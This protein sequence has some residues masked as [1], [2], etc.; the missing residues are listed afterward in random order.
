MHDDVYTI[1]KQEKYEIVRLYPEGWRMI[2]KIVLVPTT[3]YITS[4]ERQFNEVACGT[5]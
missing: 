1:M 3:K 5:L 4:E 2:S